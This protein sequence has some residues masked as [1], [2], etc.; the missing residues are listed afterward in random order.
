M[1]ILQVAVLILALAYAIA[2]GRLYVEFRTWNA[3]R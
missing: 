2:I 1:R 3:L